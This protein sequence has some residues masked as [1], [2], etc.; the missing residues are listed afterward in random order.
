MLSDIAVSRISKVDAVKWGASI[1]QIGG[2]AATGL[3]HA[4]LAIPLFLVGVGGW[5]AVGL[6]W[7]DRA[8]VLIHLVAL[9]AMIT[10]LVSRN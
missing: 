4:S 9:A 10:G 3:G 6:A 1:A 8:I 2:Y 7:R 5:L